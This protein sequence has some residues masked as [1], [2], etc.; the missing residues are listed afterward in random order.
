MPRLAKYA[1]LK[2]QLNSCENAMYTIHRQILMHVCLHSSVCSH[3]CNFQELIKYNYE[4]LFILNCTPIYSWK[5]RKIWSLKGLFEIKNVKYAQTSLYF[6]KTNVD[7]KKSIFGFIF[8]CNQG[9]LIRKVP[10]SLIL[11]IPLQKL[12]ILFFHKQQKRIYEC[13]SS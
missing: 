5:E 10:N 6:I 2:Y 9:Q 13:V 1:K 7:D 4:C 8:I 11:L 12:N 3:V